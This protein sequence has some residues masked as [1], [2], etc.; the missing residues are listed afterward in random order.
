MPPRRRT[1]RPARFVVLLGGGRRR[2]NRNH[3]VAGDL[4]EHSVELSRDSLRRRV[5]AAVE[6]PRPEQEHLDR[7]TPRP[8]PVLHPARES[9]IRGL[10]R[11]DARQTGDSAVHHCLD[12]RP[13]RYDDLRMMLLGLFYSSPGFVRSPCCRRNAELDRASYDAG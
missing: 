1:D 5:N 13:T 6:D 2:R 12:V 8:S 9:C 7:A 10:E 3:D 11:P 4:A